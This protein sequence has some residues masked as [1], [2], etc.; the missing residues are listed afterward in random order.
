MSDPYS[1]ASW[2]RIR[3]TNFDTDPGSLNRG[4]FEDTLVTYRYGT[5]TNIFQL[6]FFASNKDAVF[7]W[8][9]FVLPIQR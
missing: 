9:P 2:I 5:G 3:N 8:P 4:F 1:M 6:D 7:S